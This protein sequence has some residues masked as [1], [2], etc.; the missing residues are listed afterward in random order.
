MIEIISQAI[1]KYYNK[2]D[3]LTFKK[4]SN[5]SLVLFDELKNYIETYKLSLIELSDINLPSKNWYINFDN[6]KNSELEISYNSQ[7]KICKIIPIFYLHHEFSIA[8][9]NEKR[10]TSDLS[11]FGQSPYII[12]QLKFSNQTRDI[13][14]KKGYQELNFRQMQESVQGFKPPEDSFGSLGYVTVEDLFFTDIFSICCN[15]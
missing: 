7:L 13:L 15:D 8:H 6:Y 3:Y 9:K 10:I 12:E 5:T 2:K 4:Y 11:D 1:D 14:K